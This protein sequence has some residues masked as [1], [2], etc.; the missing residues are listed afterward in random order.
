VFNIVSSTEIWLTDLKSRF[1]TQ[2]NERN[3]FPDIKTP[4]K[5]NDNINFGLIRSY[6]KTASWLYSSIATRFAVKLK[7]EFERI[8][9]R[10]FSGK[11]IKRII[12]DINIDIDKLTIRNV[13][14]GQFESYPMAD[15]KA[16]FWVKN[17][18][19]DPSRVDRQG[20]VK[21]ADPSNLFVEFKDGECQWGSQS[22]YSEKSYGFF[23]YPH[24]ADSNNIKCYIPRNA[25]NYVLL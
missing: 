12:S 1:G 2:L 3:I 25:V 24:D 4:V 23:F 10:Y 9:I 7:S 13:L 18:I 17:L 20:F 22:G 16:V 15:L 5:V 8:V 11:I 6:I 19:G 14:T 21:E